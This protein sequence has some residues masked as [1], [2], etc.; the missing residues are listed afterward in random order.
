[1][2][3][4]GF[5]SMML[6]ALVALDPEV[7]DV[8]ELAL[9]K[10]QLKDRVMLAV[11]AANVVQDRKIAESHVAEARLRIHE[12]AEREGV[13]DEVIAQRWLTEQYADPGRMVQARLYYGMPRLRDEINA[14]ADAAADSLDKE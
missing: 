2:A 13:T 8:D 1:M 9:F 10:R 6:E 14:A 7:Y 11:R 4:P 5:D 12:A 3:D